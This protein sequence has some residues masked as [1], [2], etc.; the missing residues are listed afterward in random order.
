MSTTLRERK[1]ARTRQAIAE[2][3]LELFLEHGFDETTVD[4]IAEAADISRRTFF[5]Y[6]ETKEAA[7]FANQEERLA[8]FQQ[9][10]TELGKQERPYRAVKQVCLEMAARYMAER[11][12]NLGQHRVIESSRSLKAYDQQLDE[13]WERAIYTALVAGGLTS[14]RARVTSGAIIGTIRALLRTWFRTGAHDDLIE[15]GHRAFAILDALEE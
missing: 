9:R 8:L 11:D 2:A 10:L 4:A 5:R 14:F 13:S 12:I 3:A 6:F 1:K 7:F 15:L